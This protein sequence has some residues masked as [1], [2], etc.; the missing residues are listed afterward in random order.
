MGGSGG[1]SWNPLDR[2]KPDELKQKLRAIEDA[3]HDTGFET[4]VAEHLGGLLADANQRDATLGQE[5]LD[6]ALQVLGRHHEGDFSTIFGGSVAK[7][8]YVEGLSDVDALLPLDG[9]GLESVSPQEALARLEATLKNGLA[10]KAEVSKGRLAITVRYPDGMEIQLLPAQRTATGV[11]VPAWRGDRWS[12]IEPEGFRKAL[13]QTN[14]DCSGK[15]IPVIKLAKTINATLPESFQLSGY[16]LEAIGVAAFR[17]YPG[18]QL[19][20]PMLVHYFERAREIVKSPIRD[21]TGQSIHV[22][23]DLGPEGSQERQQTAHVLDRVYRRLRNALGA[24]SLEQWMD[25]FIP[26]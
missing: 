5:R 9:T 21:R 20:A 4:Q 3:T 7:R 11:R 24:Q 26:R 13:T 16:H 17:G 14:Q 8:T 19:H 15:L 6:G 22:D 18:A 12:E 23:D 25:I 1:G 10:G 2:Y